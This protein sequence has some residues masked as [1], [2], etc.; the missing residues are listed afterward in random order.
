MRR[1]LCAGFAVL[2]SSGQ[3]SFAQTPVDIYAYFQKASDLGRE[4]IARKTKIVDAREAKP[5]E[6]IVT[7]LRGEGKEAQSPHRQSERYGGSQSVS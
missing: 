2:L 6:V 7:I 5:G 4:I 3:A 1:T